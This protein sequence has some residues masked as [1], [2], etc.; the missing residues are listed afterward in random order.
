MTLRLADH[1]V[2][3]RFEA[4]KPRAGNALGRALTRLVRGE[5][6]VLGVDDQGWAR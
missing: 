1:Q 6:V 4:D 5:L 3:S 2:P